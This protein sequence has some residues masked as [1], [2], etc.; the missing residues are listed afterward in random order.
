MPRHFL[1]LFG[2]C[3]FCIPSCDLSAPEEC[4]AP[5]PDTVTLFDQAR[6]GTNLVLEVESGSGAGST[7]IR[8]NASEQTT[9]L[10]KRNESRTLKITVPV[11]GNYEIRLAYS[12]DGPN[13]EDE[14]EITVNGQVRTARLADTRRNCAAGQGWNRIYTAG[15]LAPTVLL[16]SGDNTVT[17]KLTTADEFGCEFDALLFFSAGN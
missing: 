13:T 15:P 1:V 14:A 16:S 3:V 7:V 12:N 10:L 2:L 9:V 6:G 8:S 4:N 17:L 11:A 5:V